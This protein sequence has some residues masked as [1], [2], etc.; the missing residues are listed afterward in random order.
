MLEKLSDSAL[1]KLYKEKIDATY[2]TEFIY[3]LKLLSIIS[4][5][6]GELELLDKVHQNH[7]YNQFLTF[8]I[9]LVV[10][11]VSTEAIEE[12]LLK[13]VATNLEYNE[14]VIKNLLVTQTAISIS[15]D[16]NPRILGI[17][18]MSILGEPYETMYEMR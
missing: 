10:E 12:I 1:E 5:C 13:K 14:D 2:Y 17:K 18:L 16:E 4:R 7:S 3:D 11:K 6:K 9:T 8:A 15:R